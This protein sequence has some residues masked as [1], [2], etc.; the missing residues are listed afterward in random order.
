MNKAYKSLL[1]APWSGQK[2]G[3]V[4]RVLAWVFILCSLVSLGAF[5]Y[6]IFKDG[7]AKEHLLFI[8]GAGLAMLYITIL[9][10][11]VAIYG[12]APNGWLPWR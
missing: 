3:V 12:K 6:Y 7:V 1:N 11:H 10:A 5:V 2:V 4:I 8:F 9:F